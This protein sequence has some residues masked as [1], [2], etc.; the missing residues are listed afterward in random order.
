VRKT[1][2]T[3]TNEIISSVDTIWKRSKKE[4]KNIELIDKV[5]EERN[6]IEGN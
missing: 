4:M 6:L 1:G 3:Q 5:M 2:R